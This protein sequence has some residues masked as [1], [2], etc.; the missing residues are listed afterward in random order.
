MAVNGVWFFQ[1]SARFP[2]AWCGTNHLIQL[3]G[4]QLFLC[5]YFFE[6]PDALWL[7]VPRQHGWR[8]A[9]PRSTETLDLRTSL[10]LSESL[11]DDTIWTVIMYEASLWVIAL[12]LIILRRC[13]EGP[14]PLMAKINRDPF[15]H[16]AEWVSVTDFKPRVFSSRSADVTL[17]KKSSLPSSHL[18][19]F[20]NWWVTTQKWVL[21]GSQL[22]EVSLF[23]YFIFFKKGDFKIY[24]FIREETYRLI[25]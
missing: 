23:F 9:L 22:R 16:D 5:R 7:S 2:S 12:Q 21:I 1:S 18:A 25:H 8:G 4:Q 20:L 17:K 14:R 15:L 24:I 13:P 11:A 10:H 3:L 19:V 6:H